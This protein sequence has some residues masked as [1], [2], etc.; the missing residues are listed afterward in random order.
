[1]GKMGAATQETSRDFKFLAVLGTTSELQISCALLSEGQTLLTSVGLEDGLEAT[2]QYSIP[3]LPK[4]I[5]VEC[6]GAAV[7]AAMC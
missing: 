2:L 6:R 3:V 5:M 4:E 7:K 1:M